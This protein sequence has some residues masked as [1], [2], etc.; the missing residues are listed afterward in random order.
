MTRPSV[1]GI[2]VNPGIEI[3]ARGDD[4]VHG[5]LLPRGKLVLTSPRGNGR[6]ADVVPWWATARERL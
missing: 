5:S 2:R 4:A 1:C 6:L 3:P